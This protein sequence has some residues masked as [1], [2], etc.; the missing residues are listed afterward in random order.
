MSP[1]TEWP[2][3]E[4]DTPTLSTAWHLIWNLC[5]GRVIVDPDRIQSTSGFHN[6]WLKVINVVLTQDRLLTDRIKFGP[7]ALK[8]QLVLNT[9]IGVSMDKDSLPEDWTQEKVL[10]GIWPITD[11]HGIG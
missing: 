6:Q 1:T 10:V 8:K 4:S 9:R 5:H 7:L 3:L 2:S 11:R